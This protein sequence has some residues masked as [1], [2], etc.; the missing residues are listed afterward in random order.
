MLRCL[1]DGGVPRQARAPVTLKSLDSI[2]LLPFGIHSKSV[3][4]KP[5]HPYG[6]E[7]KS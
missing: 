3:Q 6:I 1:L 5:F 2:D 7:T 4:T